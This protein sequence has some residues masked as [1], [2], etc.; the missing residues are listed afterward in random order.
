MSVHVCT[1]YVHAAP[2]FSYRE[3][4]QSA[5]AHRVHSKGQEATVDS[6]QITGG[7]LCMYNINVC[8]FVCV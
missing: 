3:Y 1:H 2:L 5:E 4:L 7:K 8:I 6:P